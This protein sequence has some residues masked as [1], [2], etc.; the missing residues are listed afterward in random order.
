[1][2]KDYTSV[3]CSDDDELFDFVIWLLF[4]AFWAVLGLRVYGF[5]FGRND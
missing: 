1:M 3:Y 5:L 4:A 2:D